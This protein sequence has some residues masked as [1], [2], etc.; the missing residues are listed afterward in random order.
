MC[1][2]SAAIETN[3]SA[4]PGENPDTRILMMTDDLTPER[5]QH[6]LLV[7]PHGSWGIVG[8]DRMGPLDKAMALTL[9]E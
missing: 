2:E 7:C 6:Y 3:F 4:L 5:S 1:E 9:R 8:W